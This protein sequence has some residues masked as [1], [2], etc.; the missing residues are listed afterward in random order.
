M[1][2]DQTAQVIYLVLLLCAVAGW[3]FVSGRANI[4]KTL[5]TALIWVFIFAG[6]VLLY[7]LRDSLDSALFV[8]KA[9]RDGEAVVLQRAADGH[10]YSTAR[11][12]DVPVRFLIDTGASGILLSAQDAERI[13]FSGDQLIF[14]GQA[15]TANGVISLA[16]VRLQKLEIAGHVATDVR[17]DVGSG[18][19]DVSLLGMRYLSRFSRVSLEGNRMILSP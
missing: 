11:V 5:Q 15:S 7:G 13:G 14:S 8:D 4:G 6:A 17:A 1:T 3:F 9:R 12:N 16:P 18:A 19:I 10:F 2:G